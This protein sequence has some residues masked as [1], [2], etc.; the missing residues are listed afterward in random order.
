MGAKN[1]RITDIKPKIIMKNNIFFNNLNDVIIKNKNNPKPNNPGWIYPK[2]RV[3][4]NNI[5]AI[6]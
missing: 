1:G 2:N 6:L 4:G 3:I 5:I